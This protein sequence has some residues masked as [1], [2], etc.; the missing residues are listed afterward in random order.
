M[1]INKKYLE[2]NLKEEIWSHFLKDIKKAHSTKDLLKICERVFTVNEIKL[3]EK[4]LGI[5]NLLGKG[6]KYRD[7][8]EILDAMPTTIAFVKK[9]LRKSKKIKKEKKEDKD[10]SLFGDFANKKNSKFPTSYSGKGRWRV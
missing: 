3:L 2:K 7:I 5:I 10:F 9:G 6:Y 1:N 4:R 8:G